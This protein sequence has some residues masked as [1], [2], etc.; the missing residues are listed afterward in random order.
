MLKVNCTLHYLNIA[1]ND[2]GNA[3]IAVIAGAL[4]KGKIKELGIW[5][6]GIGIAGAKELAT[7]LSLNRSIT[8]LYLWDNPITVE[9]AH[10]IL[11]SALD[12][13]VCQ[14]VDIDKEYNKD[15]LKEMMT[16]LE[17]KRQISK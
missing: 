2:L 16:I 11:Q 10:L 13:E 5:Q 7:C 17:S 8:H 12:N 15:E 1:Q 6:C 4:A 14:Q 9:G 3:G